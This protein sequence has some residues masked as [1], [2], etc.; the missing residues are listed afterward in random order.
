MKNKMILLIVV[1]IVA[2]SFFAHLMIAKGCSSKNEIWEY[3]SRLMDDD[4]GHCIPMEQRLQ[5]ANLLGHD[6]WELV[7][8]EGCHW[9]FKRRVR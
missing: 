2:L 4:M 6:G 9:V 8:S 3:T 7:F 1:L 5:L